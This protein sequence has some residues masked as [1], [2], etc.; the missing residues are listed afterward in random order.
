[1]GGVL[2]AKMVTPPPAEDADKPAIVDAENLAAVAGDAAYGNVALGDA[3]AGVGDTSVHAAALPANVAAAQALIDALPDARDVTEE[4]GAD[5][6]AQ[7]GAI[8]EA[9]AALFDDELA[10]LDFARYEAAAAALGEDHTP[11]PLKNS[12]Q[13]ELNDGGTVVLG[14]NEAISETLVVPEGV[15][16]T[17]DLNGHSITMTG[18]GS[19]IKVDGGSLTL[20]DSV[21]TGTITGGTGAYLE[22][23]ASTVGGGVWV[24]SGSF[25][26]NGGT[27]TG[28]SARVGGGVCVADANR[29]HAGGGTFVMDGGAIVDCKA[30]SD[31][32][33]G[34]VANYSG[35]FTLKNGTITGCSSDWLG[36]A[37]YSYSLDGFS[38][39]NG[40]ITGCQVSEQSSAVYME[41]GFFTMYGGTIDADCTAAGSTALYV[42]DLQAVVNANGG[43]IEGPVL[44]ETA[45]GA[46]RDDIGYY[47][48]SIQ[49][50]I[51]GVTTEFFGTVTNQGVVSAG[52]YYGGLTNEFHGYVDGKQITFVDPGV[53]DYA[54]EV[55][56]ADKVSIAPTD[57]VRTGATFVAWYRDE[58]CTQ[59]Y[60]FGEAVSDDLTLYAGWDF[61]TYTVTYASDG[62][63]EGEGDQAVKVHDRDL[64]LADALFTRE[65]Y[66]QVGWRDADGNGMSLGGIYDVNAPITLYP[67]WRDSQAPVIG[68]E[69]GRQ[70]CGEVAF[71]VTDNE[72]VMLVEANGEPLTPGADGL[73]RLPA[74]S[75]RVELVAYD[76]ESNAAGLYVTVGVGH[77]PAED[78]G[79]CTTSVVCTSCGQEVVA[80]RAAHD[81]V[82]VGAAAPT[83]EQA[84]VAEHW[85]CSVCGMLFADNAASKVLTEADLAVDKLPAENKPADSKPAE[86]PEISRT[87]DDGV[88]PGALLVLTLAGGVA[89]TAG[90]TLALAARG[91]GKAA[92]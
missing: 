39:Y 59:E 74:G 57:P 49:S 4:A 36:A 64:E 23:L 19:V 3:D 37:V 32:I 55:V 10:M 5:L 81:L 54:V 7:L 65:G 30:V 68:L 71:S 24:A 69:L 91:R 43:V 87:G 26:M 85:R 41:A 6:E 29:S 45:P 17:L 20:Q 48:P 60:V 84:G 16:V 88:E 58:A 2:L 15:A 11:E 61:D 8:D 35:R 31:G 72:S 9:K 79:D 80:A 46:A 38:M 33:G 92:K 12:L 18:A 77:T 47:M 13:K 34:G 73:Y 52:I 70:Y 78:D 44:F 76:G 53:G 14:D 63:G 75:G 83:Y 22:W 42:L 51:S 25:V 90:G 67:V 28:C 82:H 40:S 86:A 21:G 89:L 1:M 66:V 50:T 27:I 62:L 56:A